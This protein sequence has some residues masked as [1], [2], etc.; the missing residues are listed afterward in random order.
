[1]PATE[2]SPPP[3]GE[4]LGGGRG[5]NLNEPQYLKLLFLL[6]DTQ[7]WLDDLCKEA[8]GHLPITGK[9]RFLRKTYYLSVPALAHIL[10]RHYYKI[11]RYPNAGK[12]TIP[13]MEILHYIR[14]AYSL[15]ATPAPGCNNFQRV[16]QAKHTIGF[17][18]NGQSTNS[19]TI[20]TDAG[21]KII[22]AFPGNC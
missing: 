8:L 12:F 1:M 7:T 11:N 10:E 14:E 22:T 21:G 4:D 19:I 9:K 6:A 16:M 15:V 5:L 2:T 18:K 3:C 13:V 17:D 20:L